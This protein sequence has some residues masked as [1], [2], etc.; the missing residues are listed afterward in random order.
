MIS[1]GKQVRMGDERLW[2][3]VL[4][5]GGYDLLIEPYDGTGAWAVVEG[6]ARI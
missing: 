1:V 2:S 5:R 6:A 4:E 3:E